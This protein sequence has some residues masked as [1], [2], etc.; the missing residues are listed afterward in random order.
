MSLFI[1]YGYIVQQ[2]TLNGIA[3]QYNMALC[4]VY[5]TY[6]YSAC[7]S[8]K[9]PFSVALPGAVERLGS[10]PLCNNSY[11]MGCPAEIIFGFVT[12]SYTENFC[13]SPLFTVQVKDHQ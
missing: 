6:R 3:L 9:Q 12:V 7:F 13:V 10:F 11:V 8:R 1:I 4:S 2:G 5:T